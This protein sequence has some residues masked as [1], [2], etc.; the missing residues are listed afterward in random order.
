MTIHLFKTLPNFL[1]RSTVDFICS[2][3]ECIT[4]EISFHNPSNKAIIYNVKRFGNEDFEIEKESL[5]LEPK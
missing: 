3:H 4:K 2:L 1:P 5:K